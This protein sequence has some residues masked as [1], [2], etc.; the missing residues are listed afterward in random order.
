[1]TKLSIETLRE[2][3]EAFMIDISRELY[4][5]YSGQKPSAELQ[6]IYGKYAGVLDADSL[7]LA[8]EAFRSAPDGSE[9]RRSARLLLDW[10]AESQ[11]GRQ[12]AALDE[13]EIAWEVSTVV[14]VGETREIQYEAVSIEISNSTDAND[15]HAIE[16]ARAS[17][18]EAELAPIKRE[19]FQREREIT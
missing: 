3:G 9:E 7:G 10:Q 11:S 19:R 2:Q 6:P 18:V 17:V 5:A 1:M 12:L 4:L 13:R 16:N 15:R 14:P 8:L